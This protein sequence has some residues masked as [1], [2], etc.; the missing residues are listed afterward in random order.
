[1]KPDA[2]T[3]KKLV[4]ALKRKKVLTIKELCEIAERS[5]MSVWRTL[6]PVG[7]CTSFNLNARYYT[8]TETAQF[9][10][11]GLWFYRNVGF[12][13]FGSLTRTLVALVHG[14]KMGMTSNELSAILRVRVQNQLFHLFATSAVERA[15]WGRAHVYLSIEEEVR[16]EQR[17]RR[18]ASQEKALRSPAT[19]AP[20]SESETIAILAELVRAPRSAARRIAA[21]LGARGL[22]ITREKVLV[23]I[24]K[25]D[26]RRKKGRRS[27]RSKS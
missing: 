7:Y 17:R 23:V 6:K 13:S 4:E 19:Q 3:A 12:S 5:P 26:L 1:M 24:E 2:A 14:S 18:E 22:E 25:Y 27:T 15:Q 16:E 8:L 20:P 21:I 9:D 10:A 11:E